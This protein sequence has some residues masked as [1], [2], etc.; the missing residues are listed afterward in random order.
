MKSVSEAIM[1]NNSAEKNG[2][3]E[4][5]KGIG[6]EAWRELKTGIDKAWD[7]IKLGVDDGIHS[8]SGGFTK[9][10]EKFAVSVDRA[11]SKLLKRTG[12][13]AGRKKNYV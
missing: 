7:E 6:I 8:A 10:W 11:K 3:V 9:G 5:V 4:I 1:R 2:V 13:K 12:V